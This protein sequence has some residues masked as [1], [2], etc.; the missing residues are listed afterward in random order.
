MKVNP[1]QIEDPDNEG[2]MIDN[3]NYDSTKDE[4]GNPIEGGGDDDDEDDAPAG[5][6]EIEKAVAAALKPIKAKLNKAYEERNTALTEKAKLEK[7]ERDRETQRLK[8]AGEADKA[9]AREL[10][11]RDQELEQ[12]REANVKLTRD[13]DVGDALAAYDFKTPRA[14]AN[15]IRDITED[16]T[17]NEDGT[18]TTRAGES[19]EEFAKAFMEQEDNSYL[20]K[21]KQNRGSGTD[22]TKTDQQVRQ[23][24]KPKSLFD[25]STEDVMRNILAGK[26][27]QG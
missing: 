13:R 16:L 14:K 15:A 11:D 19:I 7:A 20:L 4:D 10:E 25:M 27:P 17:R 2:Q 9:H 6:T 18:W 22:R 12:L 5:Q 3:P 1:K 26:P 8:D 24:G 21:P 23:D